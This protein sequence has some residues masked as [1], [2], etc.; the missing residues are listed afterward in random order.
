MRRNQITILGQ[1][2]PLCYSTRVYLAI[3]E[4]FGGLAELG[5]ALTS[6]DVTVR[7][8]ETMWML[9]QLIRAGKGYADFAGTPAPAPLDEAQLLA[10]FGPEEL[11]T[12]GDTIVDTLN[13]DGQREVEAEP[14]KN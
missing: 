6:E 10:V 8:K 7:I 5:K 13:G 9:A 2:R 3:N 1:E 12:L 14:P 11:A 4:R